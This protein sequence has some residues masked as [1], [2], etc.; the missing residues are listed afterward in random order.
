MNVNDTIALMKLIAQDIEANKEYLTQLDTAIGDADHGINL[1]RGFAAVL[2]KLDEASFSAPGDVLKATAM[3]LISTVGGASGPLYGTLF[4]KM[5]GELKADE[6]TLPDFCGALEAGI[7]GV[8]A[9]GRSAK[10]EKT[11]L[12]VLIPVLDSLKESAQAGLSAKDAFD[13]AALAA[14]EGC[15]YT[16]TIIATKGRA[17]YLGERSLGHIDPG[18]MSSCL[19]IKAAAEFLGGRR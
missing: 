10:G 6:I 1:S 11:M 15:E 19:M 7:Q 5:S 3:T 8:M 18:C 14:Q 12:D 16:K 9:R 2:K 17:S 4:L 13:K